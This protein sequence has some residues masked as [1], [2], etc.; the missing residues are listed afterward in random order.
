MTD[1]FDCDFLVAGSGFGGAVASLRL[2]EKGYRVITVEKGRRFRAADFPER[3]QQV[4]RYLWLPALGWLGPFKMTFFRHVGIFSGVGFGGGSLVYANT[5]PIPG[6]G[7]FQSPS[8]S[9]LC[10]WKEELAPWYERARR[11]LGAT[12]QKYTTAADRIMQEVAGD[13]GIAEGPGRPW[14]SVYQ[15]EPDKLVPDPYFGGEGPDRRGC[16]QCGR[17]MLGCPHNA[18][19]S[20]DKNYLWLAEK[21]GLGV[22]TGTEVVG[23]RPLPGGGYRVTLRQRRGWLRYQTTELRARRVIFAGGVLGTVPLLTRLKADP[24][25]L[26]LL[27]DRLGERVRT[28]NE[29][30]IGVISVEDGVDYSKGVTITSILNTDEHSHVEPVR[31]AAGSDL[32]KYLMAPHGPGRNAFHSVVKIVRSLLV[33][34]SRW[35]RVLR[36]PDFS[37]NTIILLYMRSLEGTLQFRPGRSLLTGFRRG[38]VSRVENGEAPTAHIPEA[39][40]IARRVARKVNGVMGSLATES[41]FDMPTTAHI[42]GGCSMGADIDEGVIDHRHEVFGYPGLYVIDGSAISANPGVNPSLTITAL[43]ERA[44]SFIPAKES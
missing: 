33:D 23:V 14:V 19:N 37:K 36:L 38:L 5:L 30:L 9:H 24:R 7:F 31:Q 42:L 26:P 41:V 32:F 35:L 10:N 44:M 2:V 28:N 13:M 12:P 21:K 1:H 11:Y 20:L 15:G 22:R 4:S 40:E 25:H 6:D 8:W 27:S 34:R 3:N 29:S 39:T 18:K 16:N 17:C 43:A